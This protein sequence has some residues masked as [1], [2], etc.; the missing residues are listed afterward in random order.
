MANA[1]GAG[2]GVVFI[3]FFQ[4][5]E[6]A[7]TQSVATSM[8][9]QCCGMSAGALSWIN[10][11][12]RLYSNHAQVLQL[13]KSALLF[14]GP[15]T[16]TGVLCGQHWLKE[17]GF[18]LSFIFKGFSIS[19]GVLLIAFT[20]WT[21]FRSRSG[22]RADKAVNIESA[23]LLTNGKKCLLVFTCFAGGFVTAWISIGVGEFV[24]L[25]LFFFRAPTTVAVALGVMTSA[26]A[27]LTG[28]IQHTVIEQN[29]NLEIVLFAGQAALLGGYVARH[30]TQFLGAERL[31]IFFA[32]WII[33]TSILMKA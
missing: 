23:F 24:A 7:P 31:K 11:L 22:I 6:M 3:P 15:A 19:F 1:T 16:I 2:G 14:S 10:A 8:A 25:L 33:L 20:V 9:I 27:V 4:Q 29:V 18:D 5:M 17:P 30:I 32:A 28:L 12:N 26:I 13:L 21:Q